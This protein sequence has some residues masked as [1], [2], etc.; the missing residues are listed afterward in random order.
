MLRYGG[1]TS[2]VVIEAEGTD[3]IVLDAGTGL[4]HYGLS[5]GDDPFRGSVLV[6][7]LHWDHIQG[8]P[9]FPQILREGSAVTLY[10]P[11]EVDQSFSEALDGFMSPPYFPVRL[12]DLPGDVAVVDLWDEAVSA[13]SARF[14]AAPVPH[15]GRTN[16]YRIEVNGVSIAYVPDHQQ[17]DD[18]TTV[19]ARVLELVDGVD[20]LIHDAQ[21]TSELFEQRKTWGHC[22]P[23]Y[24]VRVAEQ[25]GAKTLAL[26]HHDPLHDDDAMDGLLEETQQLS[27]AVDVVCAAEGLKISF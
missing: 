21:Y 2:C 13:G 23:A 12:S 3:P 10:G 25:A 14:V 6:T 18:G 26:F 27:S 22:T 9:F 24:A 15:T 11:P 5:V 20:L 16:G 17:P 19:D 1:N 4:R 8:L 7:H